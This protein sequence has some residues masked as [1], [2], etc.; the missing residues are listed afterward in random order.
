MLSEKAQAENLDDNNQKR[1]QKILGNF[2]YYARTID[3]TI[4][5]ALNS[6]VAVQTKQTIETANK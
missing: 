6:L 2:L 5:V 3:H 4:L 1:L